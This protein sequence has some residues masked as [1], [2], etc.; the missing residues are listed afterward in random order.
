[1]ASTLEKDADAPATPAEFT[2]TDPFAHG[3]E[4]AKY[5]LLT[6]GFVR[7]ESFAGKTVLVVDPE[8]LTVLAREA[9]R[10]VSFLLRPKH[11]RQVAKI[12]EDPEASPNDRFVAAALLENAAVSAKFE[13]PFCQ[14]TGTATVV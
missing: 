3:E 10:D 5:R 13:L 7:T 8:A 2:Y 4:G 14:D 1:M 11:Q 6:S 12:L 9:M